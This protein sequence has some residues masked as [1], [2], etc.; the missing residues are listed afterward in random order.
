MRVWVGVAVGVA[1]GAVGLWA[2]P[3]GRAIDPANARQVE[4]GRALYAQHCASC[5]GAPGHPPMVARSPLGLSSLLWNRYRPYN[6]L[7]TILDGIWQPAFPEIG[8]MPAFR[9]ALDDAQ[10]TALAA[11][12]RQRYAPGQPPWPDLTAA[13]ARLRAAPP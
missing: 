12:M 11:W 5:H 8:H 2:W 7:R 4:Q 6:L 13:V 9:H 1:V 10:I 3:K